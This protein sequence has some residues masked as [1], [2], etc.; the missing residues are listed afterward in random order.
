MVTVGTAWVCHY[1]RIS[2]GIRRCAPAATP[3]EYGRE[4]AVA[5][6]DRAGPGTSRAPSD[7]S[8]VQYRWRTR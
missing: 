5:H 2:P 1:A 3:R 6:D 8:A 7:C 4:Y